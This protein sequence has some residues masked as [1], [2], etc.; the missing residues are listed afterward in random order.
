VALLGTY[1]SLDKFLAASVQLDMAVN[2]AF[3]DE[4]KVLAAVL[5]KA[6]GTSCGYATDPTLLLGRGRGRK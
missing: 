4:N 6:L 3:I 5:N 1:E 2:L